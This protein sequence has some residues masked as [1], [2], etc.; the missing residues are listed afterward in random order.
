MDK[1]SFRV[2]SVLLTVKKS[3]QTAAQIVTFDNT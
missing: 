2:F 3:S 1:N